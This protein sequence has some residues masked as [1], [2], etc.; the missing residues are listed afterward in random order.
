MLMRHT[1]R[2]FGTIDHAWQPGALYKRHDII[3]RRLKTKGTV[4]GR[5]ALTTNNHLFKYQR[6]RARVNHEHAVR[7]PEKRQPPPASAFILP[8]FY[9]EL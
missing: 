2:R 8:A 7:H 3:S 5:H 4:S 9:L 6:S 1:K